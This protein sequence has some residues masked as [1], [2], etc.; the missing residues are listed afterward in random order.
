MNYT[1]D[2]LGCDYYKNKIGEYKTITSTHTN[3]TDDDF[4]GASVTRVYK[5]GYCGRVWEVT[6]Q[7]P[8][9]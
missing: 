9:Q 5:C 3:P 2:D 7:V 4:K 8:G 6:A 1:H